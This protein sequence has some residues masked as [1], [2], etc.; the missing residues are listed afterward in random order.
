MGG[1]KRPPFF[2]W[3]VIL[4]EDA[5]NSARPSRRTCCSLMGYQYQRLLLLHHFAN[6]DA[7][8]S[9]ITQLR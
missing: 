9:G 4:S 6:R 7:I 8:N 3:F 5:L 1:L 2:F